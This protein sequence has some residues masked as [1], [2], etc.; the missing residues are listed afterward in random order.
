DVH[1]IDETEPTAG[2]GAGHRNPVREMSQ[3]VPFCRVLSH[4]RRSNSRKRTHGR[5]AELVEKNW[6][7][8]AKFARIASSGQDICRGE[9]QLVLR[10]LPA[11]GESTLSSFFSE[12]RG[13]G[14]RATWPCVRAWDFVFL[15]LRMNPMSST[16]AK[17]SQS[18]NL[19]DSTG[20]FGPY[21][22]VFVPETLVFAL[23]PLQDEYA[24]AKADQ[25]FARELEYYFK[26][27]VGRPSPLY[28][29]K[30]LTEHL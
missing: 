16:V 7:N 9:S 3:N 22:G 13:R 20:H 19:P 29:A 5:G 15:S 24:R 11:S 6:P 8:K 28:F 27:F 30:R 10:S 21:G 17:N 4:P 12:K 26:H 14:A 2:A 18:K 23:Q 25:N 1:Q